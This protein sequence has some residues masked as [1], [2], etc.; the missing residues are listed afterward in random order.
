[1]LLS[2]DASNPEGGVTI[3]LAVRLLPDKVKDWEALAV[4]V[5]LAKALSE[6]VLVLS[7]GLREF[8]VPV[9]L[10][11]LV[12]APVEEAFTVP[13]TVPAAAEAAIRT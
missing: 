11:V 1:M 6:L 4:P 2:V 7:V 5:V 12:A 10:T 9:R 8:T 13:V 3:A